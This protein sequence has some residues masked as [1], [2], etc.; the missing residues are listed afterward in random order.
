[1]RVVRGRPTMWVCVPSKTSTPRGN[2]AWLAAP[3]VLEVVGQAAHAQR[4]RV[5]DARAGQTPGVCV[6][7]GAIDARYIQH[8]G[9]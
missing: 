4:C 3:L 6:I 1:M 8:A 2:V 5:Q 9:G 7:S